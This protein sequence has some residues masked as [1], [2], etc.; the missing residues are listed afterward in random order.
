M[1]TEILR[2]ACNSKG[3]WF[4]LVCSTGIYAVRKVVK[5]GSWSK[6]APVFGSDRE[7]ALIEWVAYIKREKLSE[8]AH[9]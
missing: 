7:A 9:G 3:E 2:K 4:Q 6:L 5:G 8:A 1:K